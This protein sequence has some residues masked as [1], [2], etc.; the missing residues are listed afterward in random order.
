MPHILDDLH[1]PDEL[2]KKF[3]PIK[4]LPYNSHPQIRKLMAKR[5]TTSSVLV[6]NELSHLL[7]LARPKYTLYNHRNGLYLCR[8][9]FAGCTFRTST[10]KYHSTDIKNDAAELALDFFSNLSAIPHQETAHMNG[11]R[12]Q[13]L[14]MTPD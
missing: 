2:N 9:D 12:P 14:M 6:L 4:P 11:T 7:H 3:P 8:V 13:I 1:I 5:S 10:P